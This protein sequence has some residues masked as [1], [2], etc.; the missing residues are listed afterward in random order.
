MQSLANGLVLFIAL[1]KP[2]FFG[3]AALLSVVLAIDWLVRTRRI[4]AFSGVAR[5]FRR[6]VD[7][8]VAPVER[9]VVRAGGLPTA[10]PWWAL[11]A[12]VLGGILVITAL[13]YVA[14]MVYAAANAAG[15]GPSGLVRLLVA[16][17]IGLLQIALLV[18]VI[19]SWFRIS[20]YRK[21]IRWA[22]VLTEPILRPLRA[23]IPSMGMMDM[24]PLVAWFLLS[25][26]RRIFL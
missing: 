3:L 18:R 2:V 13:E 17:I 14:G 16:W 25:I 1:L 6:T 4:N 19:A 20:E 12:T 5:F 10:A 9:A 22:V 26:L 24:T 15:A 21:W 7:P 23:I 11:V 8:L